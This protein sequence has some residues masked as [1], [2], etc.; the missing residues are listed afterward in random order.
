[1]QS[2]FHGIS[3]VNLRQLFP[4][5]YVFG[6]RD[7]AFVNCVCDSRR[8]KP[9]DVFVAVKGHNV[10]GHD[11]IPEAV[12]N[13]AG[14]IVAERP[15]EFLL[16]L[17]SRKAPLPCLLVENTRCA[18]VRMCQALFGNP[19]EKLRLIGITGTSG[20]TTTA[21]LIAGVLGAGGIDTGIVS[22]LGCFD[23]LDASPIPASSLQPKRLHSWLSRMKQNECTCAV[24]E[25]SSPALA[26]C[27]MEG[28]SLQTVCM[29]NVR[30]RHLDIHG[31]LEAYRKAK[32]K[33]FQ[34][35]ADDGVAILN[36]DDPI[37]AEAA[38]FLNFPMLTYGVENEADIMA[39]PVEQYASEQ[40]VLISAGGESLPLRTRIVGMPYVYDCLAAIAVGLRMNIP[41][42][43]VIRGIETVE[44][45]PG[46]M[47]RIEC[48]QPFGV[49]VDF[50]R[51]ADELQGTLASLREV[52]PGRL[53]CV[54]GATG[55]TQPSERAEAG[56]VLQQTADAVV[57][58]DANPGTESP[59]RIVR[60]IQHGMKTTVETAVYHNRRDA[61]VFALSQAQP[62]DC[63]LIAGKGQEK[64]QIVNE[65]RIRHDDREVARRWLFQNVRHMAMR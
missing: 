22:S 24:L 11:F 36:M 14:A 32:M 42:A 63:V 48:G 59:D 9:G 43:T 50:A 20:K 52:T 44:T 61:I 37:S 6:N 18:Y 56:R 8:V 1:M 17:Q 4:N 3:P 65:N 26:K 62:G 12:Q 51:S 55:K 30:Q 38:Q 7:Y 33:I 53:I 31:S 60:D 10:D 19:G 23:G 15:T 5:A 39:F 28:L 64:F 29:T 16:Q 58:T 13:G 47:E 45:I 54:F 27:R 57:L 34:Y 46:R 35:L 2:C 40:T 21:C 25:A 49:F 41:L